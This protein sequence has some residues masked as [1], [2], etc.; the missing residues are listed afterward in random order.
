MKRSAKKTHTSDYIPMTV[1][2]V[3]TYLNINARKVQQLAKDGYI[4]YYHLK[5]FKNA[6]RFRKEDVMAYVFDQEE[7]VMSNDEI[8]KIGGEISKGMRL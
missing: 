3:A 4:A 1:E 6:M 7:R 8:E 2:M 5:G